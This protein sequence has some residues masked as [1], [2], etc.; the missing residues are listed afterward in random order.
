MRFL[1]FM[2]VNGIIVF[3]FAFIAHFIIVSVDNIAADK[4]RGS[5]NAFPTDWFQAFGAVPNVIYALVFMFN[6]F[7]IYKGMRKATDHK[8]K[9]VSIVSILICSCFYLTIGILGYD[10]VGNVVIN[11]NFLETLPYVTTDS[12]IYYVINCSFLLSVYFSFP[13]M[14]FGSRNNF[15][16]LSDLLFTAI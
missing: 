10:L 4:P 2:G 3:V 1:A 5:M 12:A 6:F 13:I 14:F 9:K 16:T 7:P 15:I 8:M 11:G